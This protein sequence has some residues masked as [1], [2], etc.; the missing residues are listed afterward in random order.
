VKAPIIPRLHTFFNAGQRYFILKG[1]NVIF[2]CGLFSFS[3]HNFADSS[4]IS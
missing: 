4:T 1:D 2:V 3:I